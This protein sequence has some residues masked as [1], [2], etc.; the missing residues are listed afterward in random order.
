MTNHVFVDPATGVTEVGYNRYVLEAVKN[1]FLDNIFKIET[2]LGMRIT[3]TYELSEHQFTLKGITERFITDET[4]IK[5][6]ANRILS[7]EFR[8][9]MFPFMLSSSSKVIV[10][11]DEYFNIGYVQFQ[12]SKKELSNIQ[13]INLIFD[14]N[15]DLESIEFKSLDKHPVLLGR[16]LIKSNCLS[17]LADEAFYFGIRMAKD[18]EIKELLP[19]FFVPSAYDFTTQDFSDRLNVLSMLIV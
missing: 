7:T 13:I 8:C 12:S 11:F 10:G 4:W 3:S 2:T 19:E 5:K 18:E 6:D 15:L 1:K 17:T 9:S 14:K 16:G